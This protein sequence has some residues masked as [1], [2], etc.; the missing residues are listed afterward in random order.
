M[1][2][3]WCQEK[4]V[5]IDFVGSRGKLWKPVPKRIVCPKCKKRY[6][7]FVRECD[8]PGCLHLYLPKHKL[9]IK[10]PKKV[11]RNDHRN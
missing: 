4:N 5:H 8:D 11:S 2:R 1:T 10:K 7:T 9:K 3:V 6:L